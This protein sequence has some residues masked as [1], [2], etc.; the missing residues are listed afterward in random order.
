[1]AGSLVVMSTRY[2]LDTPGQGVARA[3]ALP[4]AHRPGNS[5]NCE[6]VDIDVRPLAN[7]SGEHA[8][9]Q[10]GTESRE[11]AHE[12]QG[13][14]PHVTE[15]GEPPWPLVHA[16]EG[17]HLVANLA[18]AGQI[19]GSEA[20]FHSQLPGGLALGREVLALGPTVHQLRGEEGDLPSKT[21][22]W[23]EMKRYIMPIKAALGSG[24]R[25]GERSSPR[26]L[27]NAFRTDVP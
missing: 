23:H 12:A 7:V 6:D 19:G 13:L 16:G 8:A 22:I 21:R 1:M 2:L 15:L 11:Q 25:L 10:A 17:L 9:D 3:P 24:A 14:E 4:H 26:R 27:R 5:N 18:V 20:V